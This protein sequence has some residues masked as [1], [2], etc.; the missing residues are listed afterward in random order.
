MRAEVL[1]L[2]PNML[3]GFLDESVFGKARA[4]GLIEVRVTDIR[5]F[6]M[7][8]HRVV[9]DAP[10]GG[11]AGMVMKPEPLVA[12][13]EAARQR[14]PEAKVYLMSPRGGPFDQ[15]MARSLAKDATKGLVLVCGRYEGMDE[16]VRHHADGEISVGDFVLSGGEL[17]ACLV[18]DAVGR[19][20]DGVLGNAASAT[21]ESFESG[22]LEYPQYTRPESFRGQGVPA[23]LLS[24]DHAKIAK[25]RRKQALRITKQRRPDL[26]MGQA[27]G[28]DDQRLLEEPEDP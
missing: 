8:K 2:F 25:W 15:S 11:G 14:L 18:L 5:D 21:H 23:V 10:Y 22:L 28:P 7:D 27:L 4:R 24:G 17:A 16:R 20:V 19:L 9:D 3:T 26:L 6:A 1:T 13:I 12:A